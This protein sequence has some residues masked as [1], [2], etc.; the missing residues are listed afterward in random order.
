MVSQLLSYP[1]PLKSKGAVVDTDAPTKRAR[2]TLMKQLAKKYE[3]SKINKVN[4]YDYF[5][6]FYVENKLIFPWLKKDT[7]RRH[8]RAINK[9][10]DTTNDGT[11]IN[12]TTST[13]TGKGYAPNFSETNMIDQHQVSVTWFRYDIVSK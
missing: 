9:K 8:I 6:C 3:K 2:I 11:T 4:V 5:N 12:T 10:E 1:N 7:L 13:T